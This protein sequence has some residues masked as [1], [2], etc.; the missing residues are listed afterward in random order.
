MERLCH[1]ALTVGL[2]S[3]SVK[4]GE[5]LHRLKTFVG[6]FFTSREAQEVTAVQSHG[7]ILTI[8]KGDKM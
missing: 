6:C 1:S 5:T 3:R 2:K 4:H 8:C 7:R